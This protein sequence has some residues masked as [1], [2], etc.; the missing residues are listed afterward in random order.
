MVGSHGRSVGGFGDSAN[1]DESF[2]VWTG[3]FRV[4]FQG[5]VVILGLGE[6][7]GVQRGTEDCTCADEEG[8]ILCFEP[9]D[10][11]KT[12]NVHDAAYAAPTAVAF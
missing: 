7:V 10:M 1:E 9:A 6:C 11:L 4:K 8:C 12:G 3:E 5:R 2:V